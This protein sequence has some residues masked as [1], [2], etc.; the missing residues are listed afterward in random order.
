MRFSDVSSTLCFENGEMLITTYT[1]MGESGVLL[2]TGPGIEHKVIFTA[3]ESYQ[4]EHSQWFE[5][6]EDGMASVK[7]VYPMSASHFIPQQ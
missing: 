6:H 1:S 4:L 7:I 2:S 3:F 5:I